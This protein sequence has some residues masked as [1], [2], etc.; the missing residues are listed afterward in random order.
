LDSS[1]EYEEIG[2]Y[3][4]A[5]TALGALVKAIPALPL[6][7]VD[8]S[9]ARCGGRASAPSRVRDRTISRVFFVFFFV[10]FVFLWFFFFCLGADVLLFAMLVPVSMP[11]FMPMPNGTCSRRSFSI[12]ARCPPLLLLLLL[13]PAV[14]R[15]PLLLLLL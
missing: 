15:S 13:M 2:V 5:S 10:F 8:D 11:V 7:L 12:N 14:V 3:G 4:K 1:S 9:L 6:Y